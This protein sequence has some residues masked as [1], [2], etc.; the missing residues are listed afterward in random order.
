MR[1]IEWVTPATTSTTLPWPS[2][3]GTVIGVSRS[4]VVP[5]PSSPDT[6]LAL[7]SV[8]VGTGVAGGAG[9]PLGDPDPTERWDR[10]CVRCGA[11][12]V[13]R[14]RFFDPVPAG[15]GAVVTPGDGFGDG[16]ADGLEEDPAW[17][18]PNS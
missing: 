2:G 10:R 18:A 6:L 12:F 17:T 8:E 13:V 5:A 3:P 1:A 4:W 14:P 9:E 7:A 16:L 11:P 15:T